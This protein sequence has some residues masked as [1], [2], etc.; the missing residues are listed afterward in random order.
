M[1]DFIDRLDHPKRYLLGILYLACCYIK[2]IIHDLCRAIMTIY[3][4]GHFAIFFSKETKCTW[5]KYGFVRLIIYF[6]KQGREE[7]K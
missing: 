7:E 6:F 3:V 2:I 5:V 1:Q 4:V